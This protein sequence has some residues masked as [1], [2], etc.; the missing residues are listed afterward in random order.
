MVC[1]MNP[2]VEGLTT[3]SESEALLPA[4]GSSLASPK[5]S[6]D[7]AVCCAT[8]QSTKHTGCSFRMF[9]LSQEMFVQFFSE[10]V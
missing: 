6:V 3:F 5:M 1:I 8:E 2:N 4:C 9:C 10:D 7:P